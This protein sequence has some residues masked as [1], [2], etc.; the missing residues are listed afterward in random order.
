MATVDIRINGVATPNESLNIGDTVT[1]TNADNTGIT[2]FEWQLVS[3]PAGSIASLV[4]GNTDTATFIVDVEGA[5]LVRLVANGGLPGTVDGLAVARVVTA[6]LGLKPLAKGE[7]NE[8]DATQGWAKAWRE[9]YLTLDKALGIPADR[10]TFYYNGAAT[11]GPVVLAPTGGVAQMDNGD[12]VPTMT[13]ANPSTPPGLRVLFESGSLST[14]FVTALSQGLSEGLAI[15][16]VPSAGTAFYVGAAGALTTTAGNAP[17]VGYAVSGSG[18][19]LLFSSGG[20]AYGSVSDVGTVTSD[21]TS[22]AVARADHVHAHG[23]KGGGTLHAEVTSS[24]AGFMSAADKTKLDLV[25]PALIPT[26]GQKDALAGT[27][28]TPGSSNQYV[29]NADA[30]MTNSRTPTGAASGDLSGT[31]PAPTV[32]SLQ[33]YSVSMATAP[34]A[35]QTLSWNGGAWVPASSG[36]GGGGGGAGGGGV[37][38]YLNSAAATSPATGLGSSPRELGRTAEVAG[39][40]IT[41]STLPTNGSYLYIAGFV[42]PPSDPGV[43]AIPAGIWDFNVWA[44]ASNN[45]AYVTVFRVSLYKY[46]GT[47]PTLIASSDPVYIADPQTTTQYTASVVVPQTTV[48]ATDRIY[49]VLEGRATSSGHTITVY[50]ADATPS[51]TH[52]TVPTVAG[53]GIVHVVNGVFQSPASPV[54]L[55][56]G[57]TEVSGTLP[58]VRGG[59]AVS[60]TPSNGQL[61]IGNGTGYTQATIT[62]TN[63]IT[64]TN[65]AGSI[66]VEVGTIAQSQVASLTTDLAARA[67]DN[68]V[69]HL[70]G[71]ETVTGAKT[72][73]TNVTVPALPTSTTHATSK[74]YV[75][76]LVTGL[77]GF[78]APAV[79]SLT[80]LRAVVSAERADKQ[81]RLVEDENAIYRY[82]AQGTGTDDNSS[83]ITPSDAGAL[84]RWFKVSAV[85]QNHEGLTGLLGGATNDHYHLTNAQLSV[86]TGATSSNTASTLVQRDASGNFSAGTI[87]AALSGNATSAGTVA[88]TNDTVSSPNHYLTLTTST[89]G[90]AALKVTSS[91]LYFVPNN[92]ILYANAFYGSGQYLTSIPNSA[93]TAT[94][95]NTASA[96][97]ARDAS[98]NF[99][100]GTITAALSGNATSATTVAVAADLT[101]G[102]A[103]AIPFVDATSGNANVKVN[104]GKLSFTPF[105]GVLAAT[106]FSGSGSGLTSIPQSAVTNLTSDLSARPTGAGFTGNVAYWSSTTNVTGESNLFWDAAADRLGVG[107]SSPTRSV[108]VV[109]TGSLAIGVTANTASAA[110][111]P[112]LSV[113][114][115]NNG[116][117]GQ[118]VIELRNARGTSAAP[119]SVSAGDILGGF[120]TWGH[121]GSGFYA[122]TRIEGVADTAFSSTVSAA[123]RFVTTSSGTEGERVRITSGGNVGIGTNN[124]GATLHIPY[125]YSNA[126]LLIGTHGGAG[127]SALYMGVSASSGGYA[128]IQAIK[129][130]GTA[131]GDIILNKDGGNLGLGTAGPSARFEIYSTTASNTTDTVQR[132]AWQDGVWGL[133][134][135][136]IHTGSAIDYAFRIRNG[137]TTDIDAL[138][139][140]SNG[141]VGIGVG[142]PGNKLHIAGETAQFPA[143]IYVAPSAHATSRRAAAQFGDWVFGQDASGNGTK[144]FFFYDGAN[145]RNVLYLTATGKVGVNSI[146]PWYALQVGNETGQ[147][148]LRIAGGNSANDNGAFLAIGGGNVNVHAIGH[149]SAIYGGTYNDTMTLWTGG[150]NMSLAPSGGN[151]G[152]GTAAPDAR[153]HLL[154]GGIAIGDAPATSATEG[155]RRSIQISTDTSYGG[156][157]NDHTGNLIYSTMA[158]G[159]GTSQL[160]IRHSTNWETYETF[161]DM[162][163]GAKVGIGT[164]SPRNNLEIGNTTANQTLRIGGIYSGPTSGYTGIGQETSRHQIVFSSW[165]DV[166][167]DTIGAKIVAINKTLWPA[168]PW[169]T[170]QNTDL[171]FFTL[172]SIPGSTDATVERMR[173]TSAG[174]IGI[175]TADPVS[176]LTIGDT[177][178]TLAGGMALRKTDVHMVLTHDASTNRGKIQVKSG[179]TATSIGT[180]NYDL[181]LNPEGGDV[182]VGTTSTTTK[183]QV[184][185]SQSNNFVGIGDTL[186][187]LHTGTDQAGAIYFGWDARSSVFPT[188]G[189]EAS[190]GGVGNPQIHIGVTRDGKQAHYAAFYDQTLRLYTNGTE[191]LRV[192]NSKVS[193]TGN[194]SV[195]T[196]ATLKTLFV[197][198]N[199]GLGLG[200]AICFTNG[201]TGTYT[202]DRAIYNYYDGANDVLLLQ[203]SGNSG[204][205]I[206]LRAGAAATY[207]AEQVYIDSAGVTVRNGLIASGGVQYP[208]GSTQFVD[209]ERL[210]QPKNF[211]INGNFD[212]W[213]RANNGIAANTDTST[214]RY[215]AP[216]RWY[217]SVS[218]GA[219]TVAVTKDNTLTNGVQGCVV[220]RSS[221]NS[222]LTDR[223]LVQE[224]DRDYVKL[225]RGRV[226]R[227]TCMFKTG[228]TFNGTLDVEIIYNNAA[229]TTQTVTA[230][231][232]PF[233]TTGY[234]S[235]Q[236]ALAERITSSVQTAWTQFTASTSAVIPTDT[237]NM[238]LRFKHT[239]TATVSASNSFSVAGVMLT[240]AGDDPTYPLPAPAVPYIYAGGSYAGELLECQ[241]YYEKSYALTTDPGTNATAGMEVAIAINGTINYLSTW[242]LGAHPRF[243]VPKRLTALS[244]AR[245]VVYSPDGTAGVWNVG[246]ASPGSPYSNYSTAGAGTQT[247]IILVCTVNPSQAV[248]LGFASGHWVADAE[249]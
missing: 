81:L 145:S 114:A 27:S 190:W 124:P 210:Y 3:K 109:G 176:T 8:G 188:A 212:F 9:A 226:A 56:G 172:G 12:I 63:G 121:N 41:S 202:A 177:A 194:L 244:G 2:V 48:T 161:P 150:R 67:L 17:P 136:Q 137:T 89:S 74:A 199:I 218:G 32:S 223:Y 60:T 51:H 160:E 88:V 130:S 95:S 178:G 117:G 127:T 15:S 153:L 206:S 107:T 65:G 80:A 40:T 211:I 13:L 233:A 49:V 102:S 111:Y 29:T 235:P 195:A 147:Q 54:N 75:D 165:R 224:I 242:P 128:N 59:T 231:T 179:G 198:G 182:T 101:T 158:G 69:V 123:I 131:V 167:T 25:D 35:G 98:G 239:P 31:Y 122:A 154:S 26:A 92:G 28:G 234:T 50:L 116:F 229:A 55:Q 10:R 159:W 245:L 196:T 18:A 187:A 149:Y 82:D 62:G 34:S 47:A 85:T 53:T 110:A 52:T 169:Y 240:D 141:N 45:Q 39:A 216:D 220:A 166:Q 205:V 4:G 30:R 119:V 23:D 126:D 135:N 197:N 215:F 171:A 6:H 33:G 20:V 133:K 132:W 64:V 236:T 16:P 71:T 46:D 238:C 228:T 157:H 248:N 99:S 5:Y 86:L 11:T 84:G 142:S 120:N 57:I 129:N 104:S 200:N 204:G 209:A 146:N 83:I 143:S 96:I 105:T 152:I 184:V 14:G 162:V 118:P 246:S 214:T 97:V 78:Y 225:L 151:V 191:R 163:I 68:A 181:V 148:A 43:T 58:I 213:Q 207:R 66:T 208:D 219:G 193:T 241:R 180:G 7:T 36:G 76:G 73:S 106:S 22:A 103:L 125:K 108:D 222:S 94:S 21:G 139:L 113:T 237:T 186:Q 77:A 201:T 100:A 243:K 87:T 90:N 93:T 183:F 189:I 72:F 185:D 232:L 249:I 140:R 19:R 217:L 247:S 155:G 138:Y 173:I 144:D 164:S 134:L 174:R 156:I 112:Q 70:A 42:T 192:D 1:L 79:Q 37:T 221:T 38:Y 168:S 203:S 115:F 227:V 44:T 230:F 170:S 61:L 24:T 91:K 175:G